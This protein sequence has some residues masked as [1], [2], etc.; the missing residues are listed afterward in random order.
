MKI[1]LLMKWCGKI[2]Y[3][4]TGNVD[5]KVAV[6]S[7]NKIQLALHSQ[8]S[9]S[10]GLND[11]GNESLWGWNF[12]C[13]PDQPQ[14]TPNLLYNAYQAFPEGQAAGA[15]CWAP[16]PVLLVPGC[17]QVCWSYT[18]A[19]S[20]CQPRHVMGW[21]LLFLIRNTYTQ[22]NPFFIFLLFA[23]YAIYTLSVRS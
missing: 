17:L 21:H 15:C 8:D 4:Q 6:V 2:W 11:P 1:V 12:P 13:C 14:G 5:F 20:L 9:N 10:Y 18:S 16:P 7:C 3:S 22:W 23:V 19:S